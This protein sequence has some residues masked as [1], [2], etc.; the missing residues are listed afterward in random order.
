M[1]AT[2]EPFVEERDSCAH[3]KSSR[4]TAR[5]PTSFAFA[6]KP[7]ASNAAWTAS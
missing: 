6:S 5:G 2:V 4:D 1:P 7:A 3:S